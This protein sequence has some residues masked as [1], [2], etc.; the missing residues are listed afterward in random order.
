MIINKKIFRLQVGLLKK[1]RENPQNFLNFQGLHRF[2]NEFQILSSFPRALCFY[3]LTYE[4]RKSHEN[5]DYDLFSY[6]MLLSSLKC[7]FESFKKWLR[8]C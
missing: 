2:L 1:E 3:Y 7:Q 6:I 4:S 5:Y 8:L